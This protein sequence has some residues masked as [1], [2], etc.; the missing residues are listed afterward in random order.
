MR[1]IY[2]TNVRPKSGAIEEY[3]CWEESLDGRE[4]TR[5]GWTGEEAVAAWILKG[6]SVYTGRKVLSKIKKG[7]KLFLTIG[8]KEGEDV[9]INLSSL[10]E[11]KQ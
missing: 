8:T 2:I 11:S 10:K 9:R 4:I 5:L 6:R 7:R 3:Y 1:K